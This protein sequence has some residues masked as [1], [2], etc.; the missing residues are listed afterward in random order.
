M[1][2]IPQLLVTIPDGYTFKSLLEVIHQCTESGNFIFTTDGFSYIQIS[3]DN[4]ILISAQINKHDLLEYKSPSYLKLGIYV[5]HLRAHTKT[6]IKKDKLSIRLYE[7]SH[8]LQLKPSTK[9]SVSYYRTMEHIPHTEYDLP[10]YTQ[11]ETQPGI[12]KQRQISQRRVL[13][14]PSPNTRSLRHIKTDYNWRGSTSR[15]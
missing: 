7:H 5:P 9:S 1:D 6:L 3:E 11:T 13:I 10:S 15:Q 12:T 4:T 2:P 8:E 14:Y